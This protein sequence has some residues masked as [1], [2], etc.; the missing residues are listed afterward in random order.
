MMQHVVA[1]QVIGS[2][3][4]PENG[5]GTMWDLDGQDGAPFFF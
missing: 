4:S 5:T 3:G 2:N 1:L